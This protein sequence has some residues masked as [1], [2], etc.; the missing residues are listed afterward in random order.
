MT[1][2]PL[3]DIAAIAAGKAALPQQD[4]PAFCKYFVTCKNPAEGTVRHPLLGDVLTC[5]R[6]ADVA[7]VELTPFPA[8]TEE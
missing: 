3:S 8:A 4:L 1:S 6:C 2:G 7:D 5:Q